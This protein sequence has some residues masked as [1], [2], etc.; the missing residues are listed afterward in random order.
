MS[1]SDSQHHRTNPRGR[2]PGART[3]ERVEMDSTRTEQAMPG[4]LGRELRQ[5]LMLLGISVAVTTLVTVAAQ[6]TVSLLG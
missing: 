4:D 5:S 2:E 6:A 3:A 1:D